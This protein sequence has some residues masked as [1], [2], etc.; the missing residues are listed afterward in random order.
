V[1]R[2]NAARVRDLNRTGFH[3][4]SSALQGVKEVRLSS[5]EALFEGRFQALLDELIIKIARQ[6]TLET[7]PGWILETAGFLVLATAIA[8]LVLVFRLDFPAVLATV[9]IVAVAAWRALPTLSRVIGASTQL[10]VALPF[11][12]SVLEYLDEVPVP[13]A[14]ADDGE[15]DGLPLRDAVVV[16]RVC[17]RYPQGDRF[18]LDEVSFDLRQGHAIGLVGRSGA[19]KST[20][21]D[22]IAG[23]LAPTSG[24]VLVD[25]QTLSADNSRRWIR[26]IG[27]VTQH[28]YMLDA[29]LAE[30]VAVGYRRDSIDQERVLRCCEMAAV[31]FL[32]EL[33]EGIWSRLAERGA[34]LSG[35]QRQR[36][37][38]A[39]VLYRDPQLVI[40]DEATSALDQRSERAIR[41]AIRS[42]RGRYTVLI[43]AHRLSSVEDCDEVVWLD[44]GKLREAG[45]RAVV[46]PHYVAHVDEP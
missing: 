6:R 11:V 34:R 3:E 44:A 30:N 43:I 7:T 37:A 4:V 8:M 26:S 46:L 35:G 42:L 27:Y 25:G 14:G 15:A 38:I 32:D 17:Y 19:G 18:A 21:A 12:E 41:E 22:V 36:V 2:A 45:P 10:R 1:L 16:E 33:P 39:R 5:A 40:L 29:S 23:L 24:R 13:V 28:P 31:D 9:S 20:L